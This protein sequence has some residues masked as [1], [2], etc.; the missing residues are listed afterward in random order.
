MKSN[1]EFKN[2]VYERFEQYKVQKAQKRRNMLKYGSITLSALVVAVA[3]A[4]PVFHGM[5]SK[6][7]SAPTMEDRESSLY[8]VDAEGHKSLDN[9]GTSG[10]G[11]NTTYGH[12]ETTSTYEILD[13]STDA[14]TVSP[15]NE[16]TRENDATGDP[17]VVTTAAATVS[18]TVAATTT[19]AS[20]GGTVPTEQNEKYD[21]SPDVSVVGAENIDG[22]LVGIK[23]FAETGEAVAA[24][25]AE[26]SAGSGVK[27]YK[28]QTDDYDESTPRVCFGVTVY[29]AL[30]ID[31]V[32][33]DGE[34]LT[35]ELKLI[36]YASD[37]HRYINIFT[38]AGDRRIVLDFS[39]LPTDKGGNE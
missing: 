5:F 8:N 7:E 29:G 10:I 37:A 13:F 15:T 3:V 14:C 38:V 18:S 22:Y 32:E 16:S 34:T 21:P 28:Y 26:L 20:T 36:D 11:G 1:E 23:F 2:D 25:D 19:P 24:E 9:V 6:A 30:I 12:E 27:R 33:D 35:Y 17:P 39:K 4:S 31:T